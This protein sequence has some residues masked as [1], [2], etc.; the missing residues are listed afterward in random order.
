MSRQ[1][2]TITA[3]KNYRLF[4]LSDEN[5]VLDPDK[6]RKL[7]DTMREYGFLQSFPIVCVRDSKKQLVVKDGQHRLAIAEEL[8]LT[9]HY[10]IETVNFD[11]AKI[12]CTSKVW[13]ARDYAEKYAA[14]GNKDYIEGL[15][16]CDDYKL[17]I[18]IGFGLLAG[19]VSFTNVQDDFQ[20]GKS[21]VKDRDYALAVASLY[22][23][24]GELSSDLKNVR[25]LQACMAVCRVQGFD[26]S[27]LISGA[28]KR[29]EKL[30]SYSTRDAYLE[31]IEDAYNFN[32]KYLVSLRIE[33]QKA[34][35]DRNAGVKKIRRFE[36]PREKANV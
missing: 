33:A 11:V 16:L 22:T 7:R 17:P 26:A 5:R 28:K 27:R 34:M 25:F 2:R 9:V 13:A 4:R 21:C 31:M 6:H 30:V 29:R 14:H 15:A 18:G 23:A 36:K 19:T 12:N 1:S 10:V 32:R 8:G 35:R 3:T 20:Q 24:M